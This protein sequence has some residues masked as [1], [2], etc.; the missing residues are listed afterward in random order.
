MVNQTLKINDLDFTD[1]TQ[2]DDIDPTN[3]FPTLTPPPSPM[4]PPPPPPFGFFGN[5]FPNTPPPPPPPLP[6]FASLPHLGGLLTPPPPPQRKVS[7]LPPLPSQV[8]H[9]SSSK[10]RHCSMTEDFCE[11]KRKLTKLHWKEVITMTNMKDESIWNDLARAEIDKDFIS[12]L[13]ELKHVDFK[14]KVSLE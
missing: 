13:F 7:S 14:P 8:Q 3:S 11:D 5:F 2:I 6:H 1:L 9:L 4:V 12:N 10:S